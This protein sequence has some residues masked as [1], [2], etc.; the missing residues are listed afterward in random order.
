MSGSGLVV[1]RKRVCALARSDLT[2]VTALYDIGREKNGDGRAFSDYLRWFESTLKIR[3]AMIIF[4]SSTLK[5][6]VEKARK[7][8]MHLT[9]II[10]QELTE[11]PQYKYLPY[12]QKLIEDQKTP[13][14]QL[15]GKFIPTKDLVHRFPMYSIII[16]SKFGWLKKAIKLNPFQSKCFLWVDA[17]ISRFADNFNQFKFSTTWID[18]VSHSNRIWIQATPALEQLIKNNKT[19][20]RENKIDGKELM[21]QKSQWLYGGVFG[22]SAKALEWLIKHVAYIWLEQMMKKKRFHTEEVAMAMLVVHYTDH[23]QLVIKQPTNLVQK[24]APVTIP[25]NADVLQLL[26][27]NSPTYA[28]HFK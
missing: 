24:I 3:S 12:V 7:K 9:L 22:G 28:F 23:F 4:V 13:I 20:K 26:S 15:F 5:E 25:F 8:M 17:G 2:L 10:T 18:E 19:K 21:G 14:D 27:K 11:I 16:Y 6:F 1:E